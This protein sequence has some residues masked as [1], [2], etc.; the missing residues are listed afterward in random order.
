MLEWDIMGYR[1][2]GFGGSGGRH[3]GWGDLTRHLTLS[4]GLTT[5][6]GGGEGGALYQQHRNLLIIFI[7]SYYTLHTHINSFKQPSER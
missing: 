1:G 7:S 2:R 3:R 5:R 4:R 6:G